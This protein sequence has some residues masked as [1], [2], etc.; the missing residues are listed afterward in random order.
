VG[1]S[2]LILSAMSTPRTIFDPIDD[3]AEE[4]AD[5]EAEA[6]LAAGRTVPHDA[7]VEWLKSWGKPGELPPPRCK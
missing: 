4:R 1:G 7:V 3:D 6:D 2:G 5:R